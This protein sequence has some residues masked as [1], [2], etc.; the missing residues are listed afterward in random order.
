MKAFY[1]L[2][3]ELELDVLVETHDEAEIERA[4]KINPR[5]L[6]VNN[7]N[8]NDFSI[9]LETTRQLRKYIPE[10]KVF[11]SESG[12]MDDKDVKFLK[13]VGVDAFLIGR[14]FMEAADPRELAKRWK[15]PVAG[16]VD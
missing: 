15:Q 4:L 13:D 2:A 1:E 9:S 3:R 5:I 6:G 12:I 7:R 10:D 16:S 8:L 11:V 14:A